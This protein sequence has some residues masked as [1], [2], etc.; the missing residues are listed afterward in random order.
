MNRFALPGLRIICILCRTQMSFLPPSQ[1]TEVQEA[2]SCCADCRSS[3][4]LR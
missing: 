3:A 4:Q 2:K 1:T